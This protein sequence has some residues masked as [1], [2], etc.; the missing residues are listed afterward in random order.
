MNAGALLLPLIAPTIQKL[1]DIVRALKEPLGKQGVDQ[2]RIELHDALEN[3]NVVLQQQ[4]AF[5]QAM[6]RE[7]TY[8][9]A[10]IEYLELPFWKR[11]FAEKPAMPGVV[12]DTRLAR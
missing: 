7:L 8:M 5:G 6:A 3:L 11:W 1:A 2:L 10:R 4:D 12:K 9:R